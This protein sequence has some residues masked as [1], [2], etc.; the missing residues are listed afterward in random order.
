MANLFDVAKDLEK[1]KAAAQ[2]AR[3]AFLR[4]EISRH[5][6]LYHTHD[7]PEISDGD[8]D[9]LRRELETIEA[10][11]PDLKIAGGPADK[12]GAEGL[13]G[14]S[15]IRH[16]IPMLSLA[17]ALNPEEA[18]DFL[19]K[20]AR[21]APAIL[22][23][24]GRDPAEPVAFVGE[25]KVDGLSCSLRYEARRLVAAATRGDGREG[26]DVTRNVLTIASVPK[27]L[28]PDA[29]DILEVRG[30][31]FMSRPDFQALNAQQ[32]SA[33]EKPFANPRNAAAGSLRQLDASVT[34]SR[35]L[36]FFA[37][38]LGDCPV[39]FA[40]RQ[41][42]MRDKL[43]SWG[44]SLNEPSC[45]F[46]SIEGMEAYYEAME[47]A[48]PNLSYDIDGLVYKIDEF[49][50]QAAFGFVSRSPRWAIAHKF[51]AEKARTRLLSI[52]IQVG[53][54]GVLTPVAE[55][56]PV[57]VGGVVVSRATLHNAD[58]IG[59]KDI[60][61]GDMVIVQRAG[62]VIPQILGVVLEDRPATAVP[63]VFPSSCPACGA[64]AHREPDGAHTVCQGGLS[65]PAQRL[66]HLSHFV[67]RDAFDIEGLGGKVLEELSMR[68]LVAQP[69]DLF[70]LELRD[71]TVAP[72]L[73][74]WEGWGEKSARK[75][76]DA[77]EA[78]RKIS[79]ERFVFSLGI[80][81]IG[82]S[83]ARLL[84]ASY[85]SWARFRDEISAAADENG[86]A[87]A[88]L[89]SI[90][91]IGPIMA[92]DLAAFLQV[93]ATGDALDD[94]LSQVE[95]QDAAAATGP[96]P[97]AG[98]TAVFTG[99]LS[100]AR[101]EAEARARALGAKTAGSVSKKTSFV[102]AGEDAGSKLE[103]AKTLGVR[104]LDE[105]EWEELAGK[106]EAGGDVA[107]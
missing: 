26:E 66:E 104:V 102:V 30:E 97:L 74:E 52:S 6:V 72:P 24:A 35:T 32:A 100:V 22:E 56:E 83:T 5:D 9:A 90:E 34:A 16:K 31:I 91:G 38:A 77:I 73:R 101:D 28:P 60:R 80:P 67:A 93:Q 23:A 54:T 105:A 3:A 89:L 40:D 62:D 68:G 41:S 107:F 12:V 47:A 1:E 2:A 58:E 37:Y 57:T 27:A 71:G 55:L 94:L 92:E 85:G 106:A 59:R 84:A 39:P 29:P 10:E 95:V 103:K 36:S 61:V 45:A 42:E 48:R 18:K 63:F 64:P 75:L 7:A 20:I 33:G 99:S 76:F 69:A 82:L 49:A 4:A 8:Y 17:N 21:D 96:A 70:T 14:F 53:R 78:R 11:R 65:C 25:P 19:E 13:E 79:L 87:R 81:Q 51:P 43:S 50:L 46:E 98:L 44:F 88:R 86:A 15:K